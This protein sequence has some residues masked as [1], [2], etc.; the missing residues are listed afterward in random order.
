MKWDLRVWTGFIGLK[1]QFRLLM[2]RVVHLSFPKM[3]PMG[4]VLQ[5]VVDAAH[6]RF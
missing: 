4:K 1:G 3:A 5:L 2:N 6:F